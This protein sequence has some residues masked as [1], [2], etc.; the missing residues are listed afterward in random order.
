M[1]MRISA[2]KTPRGWHER[3][4]LD[5]T[6]WVRLRVGRCRC[7]SAVCVEAGVQRAEGRGCG[8]GSCP[9]GR[10]RGRAVRVRLR[11]ECLLMWPWCVG[12]WAASASV[13]LLWGRRGQTTARGMGCTQGTLL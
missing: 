1:E 12:M 8:V 3:R 4:R 6:R 11:A 5:S 13:L 2:M 7:C 9:S 10:R